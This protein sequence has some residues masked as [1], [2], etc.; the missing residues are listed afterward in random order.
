MNHEEEVARK[1]KVAKLRIVEQFSSVLKDTGIIVVDCGAI[2][3][4]VVQMDP[5]GGSFSNIQWLTQAQQVE[6]R[7]SIA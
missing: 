1:R 3:C 6:L 7:G 4:A 5:G 2:G